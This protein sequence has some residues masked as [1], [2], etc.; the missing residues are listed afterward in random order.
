MQHYQ[1]VFVGCARNLT[2]AQTGKNIL[3]IQVFVFCIQRHGR[4]RHR[5]SRRK[6][7]H[8][9][10]CTI[11]SIANRQPQVSNLNHLLVP[12][13]G[14]LC[15][16]LPICPLVLHVRRKLGRT[17]ALLQ[18]GRQIHR[19][20]QLLVLWHIL[21]LKLHPLNLLPLAASKSFYHIA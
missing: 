2:F 4:T 15:F 8:Q 13:V 1:A 14:N 18:G 21:W 5:F 17:K 9:H 11:E 16:T 6:L 12:C 3:I 7:T 10:H 20:H 19:L